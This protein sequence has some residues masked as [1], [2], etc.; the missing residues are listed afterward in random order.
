M[1]KGVL[2]ILLNSDYGVRHYSTRF[3]LATFFTLC[4][5][6]MLPSTYIINSLAVETVEA[7]EI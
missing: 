4:L 6:K 1:Q 5:A 3:D 7:N 2:Y